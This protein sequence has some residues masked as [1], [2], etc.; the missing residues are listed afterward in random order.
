MT[1]CCCGQIPCF[2][3]DRLFLWAD[4]LFYLWVVVSV[5]RS[6]VS[7]T[8]GCFCGQ[9]PSF[10]YHWLF[11]WADPLFH[12][13][14][15]VSVGRSPVSADLPGEQLDPRHA[16][17]AVPGILPQ[18][19]AALLALRLPRCQTGTLCWPCGMAWPGGVKHWPLDNEAVGSNLCSGNNCL[20]CSV[21]AK[22]PYVDT[23][24]QI[25]CHQVWFCGFGFSY[26]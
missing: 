26:K 14:L 23:C 21:L 1:G 6:P 5:G 24:L 25:T 4:P 20:L 18:R 19:P 3:Y 22:K 16:G 17:R 13:P 11:L 2:T 10:T 15:A 8:T 9:I 12:L 7:L